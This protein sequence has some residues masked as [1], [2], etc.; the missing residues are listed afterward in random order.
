MFQLL[1]PSEKVIISHVKPKRLN[2]YPENMVLNSIHEETSSF[3]TL[4][5]SFSVLGDV[6]NWDSASGQTQKENGGGGG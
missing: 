3:E 6:P 4:G 5:L 1:V 2:S